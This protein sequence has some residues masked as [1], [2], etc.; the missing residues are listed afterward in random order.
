MVRGVNLPQ[1]FIV[2]PKLKKCKERMRKYGL[3]I[4]FC[5]KNRYTINKYEL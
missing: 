4:D 5:P 1:K 2:S 3:L